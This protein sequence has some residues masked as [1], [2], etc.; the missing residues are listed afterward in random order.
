MSATWLVPEVRF[1]D[2]T[3]ADIELVRTAEPAPPDCTFA[4]TVLLTDATGAYAVVYSVRR[5]QW[6]PPGGWREA[7]ESVADCARRE[8]AEETGVRLVEADLE[9]FG[10][11]RFIIG[12]PGPL[13]QPGR[14]LLQV[15]RAGVTTPRP[16]LLPSLD[17]T[18]AQEW[19]DAAELERRCGAQFWWPLVADWV[20]HGL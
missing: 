5:R 20:A 7:E 13:T 2:G 1:L 10:W 12:T 3:V 8:V 19:V 14:D 16:P 11:E 17:D 15:Y 18:S 6:G 9:P 4:A